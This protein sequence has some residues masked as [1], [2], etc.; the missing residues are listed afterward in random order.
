MTGALLQL[1]SETW[2]DSTKPDNTTPSSSS[3]SVDN[4]R[5]GSLTITRS[6]SGG[7]STAPNRNNKISP[8]S[9]STD[10]RDSQFV[11]MVSEKQ[12]RLINLPSQVCSY[13]ATLTETSFAVRADVVYMKSAGTV[14]PLYLQHVDNW[15]LKFVLYYFN[16]YIFKNHLSTCLSVIY[17][18]N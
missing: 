7:G 17:Y 18:R 10:M 2:K 1:N 11:V 15:F 12:I 6:G 13:K 9:S 16:K 14:K 3:S 8:T 5:G 4:K